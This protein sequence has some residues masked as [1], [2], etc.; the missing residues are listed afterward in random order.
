MKKDTENEVAKVIGKTKETKD[1]A[2]KQ[3][4]R[5]VE[6]TKDTKDTKGRIT[7]NQLK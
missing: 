7:M 6:K 3:S 1:E 5:M 2:E 4:K